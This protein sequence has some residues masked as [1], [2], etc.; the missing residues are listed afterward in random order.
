MLSDMPRPNTTFD[1]N[2]TSYQNKNVIPS[3]KHNIGRVMICSHRTWARCCHWVMNSSANQN[4]PFG[5]VR[6]TVRQLNTGQGFVMR[7]VNNPKHTDKY[8]IKWLKRPFHCRFTYSIC[9]AMTQSKVQTWTWFK[10][11]RQGSSGA[12]HTLVTTNLNDLRRRCK[13]EQTKIAPVRLETNN[14]I[15]WMTAANYSC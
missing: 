11:L 3:D 14:V 10:I 1:E 12:E 9:V 5:N 8:A 6:S 4:I 15:Q 7:N 2:Q 13:E